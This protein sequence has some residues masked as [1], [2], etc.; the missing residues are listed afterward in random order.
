MVACVDHYPKLFLK[1][2][3][4]FSFV[5][6][7]FVAGFFV[8]DWRRRYSLLS[9]HFQSLFLYIHNRH[10]GEFDSFFFFLSSNATI[11]I[12]DFAIVELLHFF[13]IQTFTLFLRK[14]K[15]SPPQMFL[16]IFSL[17]HDGRISS[18]FPQL[19]II[20]SEKC[21]TMCGSTT[22][23]SCILSSFTYLCRFIPQF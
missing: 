2:L 9:T 13:F 14:K 23:T 21:G 8:F 19:Y 1:K 6:L 15:M 22:V 5:F 17:H 12:D 4:F 11:F 10:I 7:F 18:C 16:V 3:F 20:G